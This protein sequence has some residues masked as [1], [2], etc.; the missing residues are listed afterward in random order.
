MK[1]KYLLFILFASYSAES[2]AAFS[3]EENSQLASIN[4]KSLEE[5]KTALHNLNIYIRMNDEKSGFVF[6][7]CFVLCCG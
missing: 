6:S 2:V 5:V 7:Y 3:E 1:I 4:Q